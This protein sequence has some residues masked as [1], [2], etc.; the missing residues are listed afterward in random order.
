MHYWRGTMAL[1][2]EGRR[3][4]YGKRDGQPPSSSSKTPQQNGHQSSNGGNQNHRNGN[5]G[6]N[7]NNWKNDNKPPRSYSA[8]RRPSS[9]RR[10]LHLWQERTLEQVLP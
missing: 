9:K 10:M 7:G 2:I 6:N 4:V 3:I 1:P 5:N 8:G